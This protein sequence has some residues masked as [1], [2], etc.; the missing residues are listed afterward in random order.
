M[1]LYDLMH[2]PW[3]PAFV[4]VCSLA[5]LCALMRNISQQ[6]LLHDPKPDCIAHGEPMHYI[7]HDAWEVSEAW[8]INDTN[9]EWNEKYYRSGTTGLWRRKCTEL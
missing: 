7:R 1:T 2:L 9:G 4:G 8:I 6:D 5:V 3:W